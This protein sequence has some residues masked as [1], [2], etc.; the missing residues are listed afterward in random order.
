MGRIGQ[1]GTVHG[2][3]LPQV[4]EMGTLEAAIGIGPLVDEQMGGGSASQGEL[5]TQGTRR[6][7]LLGDGLGRVHV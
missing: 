3:A 1:L 7:R 6:N 4:A 5:A 2:I